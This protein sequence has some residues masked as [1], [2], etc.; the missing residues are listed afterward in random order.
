MKIPRSRATISSSLG[1]ISLA[2]PPRGAPE[3]I[4]PYFKAPNVLIDPGFEN[5]VANSG[6]WYYPTRTDGADDYAIPYMD[7]TC[8]NFLRLPNGNCAT[9][10][11]TAWAQ[12]SGPYRVESYNTDLAW[13]VSTVNP[14]SGRFSAVWW[15]PKAD[16]GTPTTAAATPPA[17]LSPLSPWLTGPF[18]ARVEPADSIT[19][20]A[21]IASYSPGPGV[22]EPEYRV[23]TSMELRFYRSNFTIVGV[24]SSSLALVSTS[25]YTQFSV[26]TSAPAGSFYVRAAVLF[27]ITANTLVNAPIL[28]DTCVLGVQ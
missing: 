7:L 5:H 19:W 6:G 8:A 3:T 23:S 15:N 16:G 26:A 24:T 9:R 2:S 27:T 28:V 13:K 10:S 1:A 18:S 21:Y 12:S 11:L 22:G 17:Q 4:D 14:H 20:S 25:S